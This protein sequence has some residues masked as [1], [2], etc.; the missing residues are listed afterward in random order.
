MEKLFVIRQ[1]YDQRNIKYILKVPLLQSANGR[2]T[3]R[4][5]AL[6]GELEGYSM[7]YMHAVATRSSSGVEEKRDSAFI[8]T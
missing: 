6:L 4:R 7:A 2:R 3:E 5:Y 1:H 8:L